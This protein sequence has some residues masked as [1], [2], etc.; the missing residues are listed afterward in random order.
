M[1]ALACDLEQNPAPSGH[2]CHENRER[3]PI[4]LDAWS[5]PPIASTI[6]CTRDVTSCA[7]RCQL[8][9]ECSQLFAQSQ[10]PAATSTP[11]RP[12]F[13]PPWPTWAG[14]ILGTG[15][16]FQKSRPRSQG[17]EVIEQKEEIWCARRDSNS[18][19]TCSGGCPNPIVLCR[20]KRLQP[21]QSGI[22]GHYRR[23]LHTFCTRSPRIT[24]CKIRNPDATRELKRITTKW[25]NGA[26]GIVQAA[27]GAAGA[28]LKM[29][30]VVAEARLI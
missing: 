13:L 4:H 24:F 10:F 12:L 17:T 25:L 6:S 20:I 9:S 7:P 1:V 16:K 28:Y 2:A 22:M 30:G 5:S 29:M 18:R 27:G 3:G 21:L 19:P 26:T 8:S 14:T 23:Q 11:L 15:Q